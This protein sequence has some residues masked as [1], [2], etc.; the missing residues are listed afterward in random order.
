MSADPLTAATGTTTF[1]QGAGETIVFPSNHTI[2]FPFGGVGENNFFGGGG[3][4]NGGAGTGIGIGG[5]G[6]DTTGTGIGI[7]GDGGDGG[8]GAQ[9]FPVHINFIDSSGVSPVTV[10]DSGGGSSATATGSLDSFLGGVLASNGSSN[11][12]EATGTAIGIGGDGG[13]GGDGAALFPMD[14]NVNTADLSAADSASLDAYLDSLLGSGGS[15]AVASLA[16]STLAD[17]TSV[18]IE[19]T[20]GTGGSAAEFFPVTLDWVDASG[21]HS[22]EASPVELLDSLVAGGILGGGTTDL[23]A[24]PASIAGDLGAVLPSFMSDLGSLF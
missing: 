4:G 21:A 19:G 17:G 1:S 9:L 6:G 3:G 11:A 12:N 24:I 18:S 20:G 8:D 14:F 10:A 16:G 7:G 13:N 5:S 15:S 23:A 2:N 22:I